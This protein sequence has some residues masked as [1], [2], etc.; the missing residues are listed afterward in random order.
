[1]TRGHLSH[2]ANHPF[3]MCLVLVGV[4]AMALGVGLV[5]MSIVL[6]LSVKWNLQLLD[7]PRCSEVAQC[8]HFCD[9][10]GGVNQKEHET[11]PGA[12][13]NS[14]QG[15]SHVAIRPAVVAS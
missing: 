4:F 7:M 13:S 8:A 1:M 2:L 11:A 9:C 3:H 15:L 14:T 12:W 5:D 6:I 10:R